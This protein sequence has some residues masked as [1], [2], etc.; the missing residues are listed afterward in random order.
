ML[1]TYGIGMSNQSECFDLK[2]IR[3]MNY[4]NAERT[5]YQDKRN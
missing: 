4:L 5:R 3:Q 2:V 1:G